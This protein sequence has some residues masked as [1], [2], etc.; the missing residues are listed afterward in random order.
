[1]P[2]QVK[3]LRNFIAG[4]ASSPSSVDIPDE[5]A[6]YSKN[7]E[8]IDEEG[9]LKG[10]QAEVAKKYKD[11]NSSSYVYQETLSRP[12]ANAK[13]EFYISDKLVYTKTFTSDEILDDWK[14]KDAVKAS[15]TAI[16]SSYP[17]LQSADI[18]N[19]NGRDGNGIN[20]DIDYQATVL[21][22]A[23]P[24][25]L[26]SG[27]NNSVE[28]V[29]VLT[30]ADSGTVANLDNVESIFVGQYIKVDS[31]IMIVQEIISAS[32][33]LI[34]VLRGQE[35]SSGDGTLIDGETE[36]GTTPDTHL[37]TA[38][39]SAL[40][41]Y[42]AHII[43]WHPNIDTPDFKIVHT[44]VSSS[45]IKFVILDVSEYLPIHARN[46]ILANK[47]T[48][49]SDKTITNVIY[50]D[51]DTTIEEGEVPH[52]MKVIEDFYGEQG[53][54]LIKDSANGDVIGEPNAV[55]LA[56]GPNGTYIGTGNTANSKS[57]WLGEILQKRFG[58][59]VDGYHLEEAQ[60]EALDEGQSLFNLD[61][62]EN[63]V[64]ATA[65]AGTPT[66]IGRTEDFII[67]TSPGKYFSVIMKTNSSGPASSNGKQYKTNLVGYQMSSISSSTAVL[68][69]MANTT[70]Q[71][72]GSDELEPFTDN[73]WNGT[74][75]N[76]A[77]ALDGHGDGDTI[78]CWQASRAD[79]DKLYLE[80]YRHFVNDSDQVTN[81]NSPLRSYSLTYNLVVTDDMNLN[82][83]AGT[84]IPRPPKSGSYISDIY[85][86]DGWVYLLYWHPSGFTF[87]EEWLY[88]FEATAGSG[89]YQ[90][91][92][93]ELQINVKPIT[94]PAIKV[95]NWGNDVNGAGYDWYMPADVFNGGGLSAGNWI[96]QCGSRG[97]YANYFYWRNCDALGY[98]A[99]ATSPDS[100]H[101][102]EDNGQLTGTGWKLAYADSIS[103]LSSS[104]DNKFPGYTAGINTAGNRQGDPHVEMNNGY[105]GRSFGASYGF[106]EYI[107]TPAQKGLTRPSSSDDIGVVTHL[108]GKQAVSD[109]NL[110]KHI[111]KWSRKWGLSRYKRYSTYNLTEPVIKDW[112]EHVIMTV[113]KESLGVRQRCV[114]NGAQYFRQYSEE[115][116]YTDDEGGLETGTRT[117][118]NT[119]NT[120]DTHLLFN[121]TKANTWAN[122][123]GTWA[124]RE[125]AGTSQDNSDDNILSCKNTFRTGSYYNLNASSAGG[126]DYAP[127]DSIQ[128][129]YNTHIYKLD[130]ATSPQSGQLD[131]TGAA[132]GNN[133]TAIS[134][135]GKGD[136][137]TV[138]KNHELQDFT[139]IT[140]KDTNRPIT[141]TYLTRWSKNPHSY[142]SKAVDYEISGN[143]NAPN[144]M[145]PLQLEG[146]GSAIMTDIKLNTDDVKINLSPRTGDYV[147]GFL[148]FDKSSGDFLTS[149][150]DGTHASTLSPYFWQYPDSELDFGMD[151]A[152]TDTAADEPSANFKNGT[153][154]YWKLS[155]LYDGFQE[156]PLTTFEFTK[157]VSGDHYNRA[158]LT[159]R[160]ADPPKRVTHIIAYRKNAAEQFYRF[161]AEVPLTH[162]WVYNS[163]KD[164]W[165]TIVVDEGKQKATYSAIT[166]MPENIS[167]TNVNY[168]LSTVAQ[169]HLI[170]ADCY[171][172]EIKQG[173]NFIFKSKPTQYSNFEWTRDYCVM[174]SKPTHIA[175][176]AGKLYVFD[177]S[178]IYRV[179]IQSLTLEDTF[180]G[181]GC[182]GPD[183]AIITD[184]G[185]FFCDYQ[186]MYWHNGSRA[187]NI[188]RDILLSSFAGDDDQ[189]IEANSL[190]DKSYQYHNW[191]HINHNRDPQVLYDGKTQSVYFCFEDK[192]D[193]GTLFSGAWVY[194]TTRKRWDMR[195]MPT[196]IG[197]LTGNRN[198]IYVS[199]T[200]YLYQIS[201]SK[202]SRK[203]WSYHSKSYDMNV[204]SQDKTFVS[205]KI[206]CNTN[207]EA[208][209]LADGGIGNWS[210]YVDN[211]KIESQY[212]LIEVDDST[213]KI[214]I[215]GPNKRGK[216][217]RFEFVNFDVEVD[218]VAIVYRTGTV[219]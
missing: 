129:S 30:G 161:V 123:G 55:S 18:V 10:C 149:T 190:T 148:K 111:H 22:L 14:F 112:N 121:G 57:M 67:G 199:N 155:M 198:D 64:T 113:N 15:Y 43:I 191:Q 105:S 145:N 19:F 75:D 209:D 167:Q 203:P 214:K 88:C 163:S 196:P 28:I 147:A 49:G 100:G 42:Y 109:L 197:K 21:C 128:K 115:Y 36:P 188:S 124:A 34:K 201:T 186:G 140:A 59:K 29:S 87:D 7:L 151:I 39:I 178:N 86:V 52:K 175:W 141:E 107:V 95:K 41:S 135:I 26:S 83:S 183:S 68:T 117:L 79:G 84:E 9:K 6:I 130:Q 114:P 126:V 4:T 208:Q 103:T 45:Q 74:Q 70:L 156:G 24:T 71:A 210:L 72:N 116:T 127:T 180:E 171:H 8:A 77:T 153:T 56:Q 46:L 122:Q 136:V 189:L 166:G 138:S 61:F 146:F 104:E 137:V 194:S 85:E 176:W 25:D 154:Y 17:E 20:N 91:T 217:F 110:G 90:M 35:S 144:N 97:C 182:I 120:E 202:N 3:E 158:T 78:Y 143:M 82:L 168:R 159:L 38:V 215:S 118:T 162:G 51:I 211:V 80:A 131:G 99:A 212:E 195:E 5:A 16:N 102:S 89:P 160:I 179:N 165:K 33:G 177:L 216:K 193:D 44:P 76:T 47:K 204:S 65:A 132:A 40:G 185:M 187:E 219:K 174:P 58:D 119:L 170:V 213:V 37:N 106:T 206:M 125:G 54:P 218:S 12:E 108:E 139:F 98:V 169:G 11:I 205:F 173:Q 69:K 101:V 157:T 50:Y 31:E 142:S 150:G 96:G 184:V 181:I 133:E 48:E 63:P 200:D 13:W 60:L 192:H 62:I 81:L 134:P 92:N 32:D 207:E 23:D 164:Q 2:K 94:P 66:G 1:M 53:S 152:Y 73:T 27:I 172:P 93:N